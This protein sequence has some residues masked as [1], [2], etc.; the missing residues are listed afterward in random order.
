MMAKNSNKRGGDSHNGKK[1]PRKGKFQGGKWLLTGFALTAIALVSAGAGSL[2]AMYS[3][4]LGQSELTPEQAAVFGQ[5]KAVSY[6]NL[7]IPQLSRP[8]N[9]LLLGTKV[10]TS[11]EPDPSQPNPGY[12][13]LVNS[14]EGLTDT[15]VLIRLDPKEKSLVVLSI[16]RDTRVEIPG[17]SGARKINQANALGGPA[18]AAMT[19]TDLLGDVPIDRYIRVNVQAVEKLIDALG[20]VDVYVPRDMKYQDDSQRLYINL[21]EGQQRLDGEKALQMLRFRYDALGDIGRI[22]RQ[23]IVMRAVVEQALKPQTILR[24]PDI[25]KILQ[26][27][28]DTNLNMEELVAIAGFS[29][30]IPRED[31]KMLML[32]G[33]FNGTGRTSISYWLPHQPKIQAMT[34]E[35]FGAMATNSWLWDMDEDLTALD[36]YGLR[37]AIQDS[38]DRPQ[39]V[40]ALVKELETAGYSRINVVSAFSPPLQ[41]TRVIAQ[42]GDHLGARQVRNSIGLGEVLV[43]SNGYLISDVTIQIGADWP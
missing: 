37:I 24:I 7:N 32:P 17:Y 34:E 13:A 41:T 23:Q 2:L 27:N 30:Q 28:I 39:A 29:A 19:V 14:V 10:L 6:K 35:Y 20:G 5:E 43:D 36:P 3:T 42:Q 8:I 26:S 22:Q 18:L 9:V 25:V 40:K 12:H 33:D 16:P 15:M 4:P 38:T 31:V 1:S 21:K 11:E